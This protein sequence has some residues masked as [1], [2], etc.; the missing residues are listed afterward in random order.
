MTDVLLENDDATFGGSYNRW[1]ITRIAKLESMFGKEWFAGK[2]ILELACA[3]GNI[4]LYLKQLGATVTFADARQEHLDIVLKKD[5]SATTILINQDTSWNINQHFDLILHFGVLYHIDNWRQDLAS[6]IQHSN[7]IL[8]E[9][10]VANTTRLFD[11]KI[12]EEYEGG[13]NAFG[14]IG[15]MPSASSIEDCLTKLGVTYTRHDDATMNT[16]RYIYDWVASD[17]DL[18]NVSAS[19][20]EDLPLYGGRRFWVI[21]RP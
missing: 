9:S 4:G 11:Y 6:V 2:H 13:Q 19:S 7:L 10:A 15:S 17:Q 16:R 5:P 8:L 20:F 21:T 1:R 14:G 3:H 18:S 12:T